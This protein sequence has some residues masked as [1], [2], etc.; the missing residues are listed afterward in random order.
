MNHQ[1]NVFNSVGKQIGSLVMMAGVGAAPNQPVT[2]LWQWQGNGGSSFGQWE[3]RL[4]G[5]DWRIVLMKFFDQSMWGTLYGAWRSLPTPQSYPQ[6]PWFSKLAVRSGEI[7]IN[8][9]SSYYSG[10]WRLL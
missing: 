6:P 7:S 9:P 10:T 4:G 2:F 3:W 5:G 1:L 8:T